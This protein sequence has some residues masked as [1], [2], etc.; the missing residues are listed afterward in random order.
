MS[1]F[2]HKNVLI[3]GGLGF[4][5]SNLAIRLV[6]EGASVTLV[7]SMIPNH[8]GNLFNIS[9]I[10]DQCKINFSDIR[11]SHSLSYLVSSQ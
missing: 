10:R 3:L 4:I 2:E 6:N 11:D 5:G 7:D 8:G 9:P 1:F